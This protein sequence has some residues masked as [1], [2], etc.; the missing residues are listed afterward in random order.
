MANGPD[1]CLHRGNLWRLLDGDPG[2]G[3]DAG[4]TRRG[5]PLANNDIAGE[6]P[7]RDYFMRCPRRRTDGP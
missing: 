6:R 4:C 2:Q 1:A 5:K 7:M 3:G